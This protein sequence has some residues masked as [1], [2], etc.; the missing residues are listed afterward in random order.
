[1]RLKTP[2]GQVK[3]T[4]VGIKKP[5]NSNDNSVLAMSAMPH[6]IQDEYEK[7]KNRSSARK[8]VK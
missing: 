5:V 4:L 1:M 3:K 6:D 2:I 7:S 8:K